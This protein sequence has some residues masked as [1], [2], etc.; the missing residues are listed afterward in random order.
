MAEPVIGPSVTEKFVLPVKN[1]SPLQLPSF[2]RGFLMRANPLKEIFD[3]LA[4]KR[5]LLQFKPRTKHPQGIIKKYNGQGI[6][7]NKNRCRFYLD[8]H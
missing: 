6:L 8:V 3:T 7:S 1:R 5:G 4:E 2:G